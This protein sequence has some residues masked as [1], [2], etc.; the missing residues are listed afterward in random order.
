MVGR[1]DTTAFRGRRA[2]AVPVPHRRRRTY[3]FADLRLARHPASLDR[4]R[5]DVCGTQPD[6]VAFAFRRGR[7]LGPAGGGRRPR[8]RA[9]DPRARFRIG[10]SRTV[11]AAGSD[12][13]ARTYDLRPAARGRASKRHGR[14]CAV[15]GDDARYAGKT[16]TCCSGQSSSAKRPTPT[17]GRPGPAPP[18]SIAT[19]R[20]SFMRRDARTSR[21]SP[22]GSG[23]KP[24]AKANSFF[25]RA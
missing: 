13:S 10:P 20:R 8:R 3:R 17:S 21:E 19:R 11:L 9:R 18:A 15:P 5:P 6:S 23:G 14:A 7:G 1:G 16:R 12:H 4:R 25:C 24:Y 22:A 2:N